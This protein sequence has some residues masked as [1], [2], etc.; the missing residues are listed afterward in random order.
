MSGQAQVQ[1]FT[2][3]GAWAKDAPNRGVWTTRQRYV[4]SLH[5]YETYRDYPA[6]WVLDTATSAAQCAAHLI[7]DAFELDANDGHNLEKHKIKRAACMNQIRPAV[8]SAHEGKP[9]KISMGEVWM[10]IQKLPPKS[11]GE[12]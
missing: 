2:L 11:V 4:V 3:E 7:D 9:V 8:E 12:Y 6:V 5:A 1:G 10:W